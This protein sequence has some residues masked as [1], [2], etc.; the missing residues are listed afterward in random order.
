LSYLANRQ[1]NKQTNKLGQKHYLLGGGNQFIQNCLRLTSS[2]LDNAVRQT[3]YVQ[4]LILRQTTNTNTCISQ[5][6]HGGLGLDE[7]RV[8]NYFTIVSLC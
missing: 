6:Y 8:G 5:L 2:K 7:V 3:T 1:T 4:T